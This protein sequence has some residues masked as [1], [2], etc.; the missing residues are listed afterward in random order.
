MKWF[1]YRV[2]R[3]CCVFFE[4]NLYPMSSATQTRPILTAVPSPVVPRT[5]EPEVRPLELVRETSVP[6]ALPSLETLDALQTQY[7]HLR[8]ENLLKWYDYIISQDKEKDEDVVGPY[9]QWSPSAVACFVRNADCTG[10]Y[11]QNFFSET[12]QGCQMNDAVKH[13]LKKL[14]VPNKRHINKLT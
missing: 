12:A 4:G 13:L 1:L 5:P 2:I 8:R 10:C 9:R 11:Y 14:G 7:P 3:C 6:A